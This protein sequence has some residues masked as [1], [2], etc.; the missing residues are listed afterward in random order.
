[1]F[2]ARA[3]QGVTSPGY[4]PGP[5]SASEGQVDAF[6]TWYVDRMREHLDRAR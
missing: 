5:Y 3:Q 6:T 2:C 4:V 1:M